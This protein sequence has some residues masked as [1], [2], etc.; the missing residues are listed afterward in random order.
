MNRTIRKIVM[1]INR[2]TLTF[3]IIDKNVYYTD[4]KL[5][6]L[7]RV[8]PKPKNLLLTIQKTRNRVPMF[9]AQLF[10]LSKA[11]IDEYNAAQTVDQLAEIIIR[12][13]KKNSCILVA[14][15]NME[16]DAELIKRIE[17]QEVVM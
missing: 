12:D 11:E 2:E 3:L 4:R 10:E 5:G 7:I 6:M 16:A 14:N 15:A 8:L 9:I 1:S 13:G 17:S